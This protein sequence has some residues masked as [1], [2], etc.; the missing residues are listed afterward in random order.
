MIRALAPVA[1][2][3]LSAAILL[4]GQGLQGTLL[5]VRA[6]L[7]D[8]STFEIGALG[9]FYF[10]GFTM[11]CLRGG[12]LVQRVGHIRVFLA[13]SAMASAAPLL[14]GLVVHPFVWNGLRFVTGFCLAALYVVIESWLNERATNENRGIIFSTYAMITLTVMAGGQLMTL[15]YDPLGWQ[16]FVITSIL[17]SIGAVPIA[18]STS[19][20][21]SQP[22]STKVDIPGLLTVS[23]SG[24]FGC[25]AAGLANG[26]F[27]S[28]TPVYAAAVGDVTT[29]AALLMAA[30]VVGGAI[31]QWPLGLLSDAISRRKVLA[32]IALAAAAIGIALTLTAEQAGPRTALA[33]IALWG[34]MAFPLYTV[35]VAYANDYADPAEFVKVS[36]GLLFVYGVGAIAGPFIASIFMDW[37]GKGALFLFTSIIHV[38]LIIVVAIRFLLERNQ[39]EQPVHFGDAL[40]AAQTASQVFEEEMHRDYEEE[41]DS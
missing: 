5:P 18:L 36:G 10:F 9:A 8:F 29:M 26:A 16:L 28:L 40:S 35:A 6:G 15:L 3:L 13:M 17:F 11:G 14:H 33:L 37:Q 41:S 24:T 19:Q 27:W 21:P 7:E 2:L 34:A 31:S 4:A 20:T 25:F 39:A 12:D 38:L 23:P 1:T 30:A 32:G 22:T